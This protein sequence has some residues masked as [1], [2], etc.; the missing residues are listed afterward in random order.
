MFSTQRT[1]QQMEP[2]PSRYD[3]DPFIQFFY[4]RIALRALR[5]EEPK[6]RRA[7]EL[8]QLELFKVM[9]FGTAHNKKAP[10]ARTPGASV[11]HVP[12]NPLA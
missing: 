10:G 3:A 8:S 11:A 1:D 4:D 7:E 12:P 2:L 5:A 9:P 6:S